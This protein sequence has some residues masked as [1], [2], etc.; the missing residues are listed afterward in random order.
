MNNGKFYPLTLIM[1]TVFSLALVLCCTANF[2]VPQLGSISFS[3]EHFSAVES[4]NAKD[5]LL[6]RLRNTALLEEQVA[7]D[8]YETAD[9]LYDPDRDSQY[10]GATAGHP[11]LYIAL[12]SL[13]LQRKSAGYDRLFHRFLLVTKTP[14]SGQM[15]LLLHWEG[16]P[17]ECLRL[18]DLHLDSLVA[19]DT[20]TVYSFFLA[21]TAAQPRFEIIH[22]SAPSAREILSVSC[23]GRG[24]GS[25][26]IITPGRGMHY[27]VFDRFGRIIHQDSLSRRLHNLEVNRYFILGIAPGCNNSVNSFEIWQP[28][29]IK[30]AIEASD[31][32]VVVG[33]IMRFDNKSAH[34]NQFL[35]DFGDGTSNSVFNPL[36]VYR[37]TG[38]FVVR[39]LA[40]DIHCGDSASQTMRV[41][42]GPEP[43]TG[44]NTA[45][46]DSDFRIAATPNKIKVFYEGQT[47]T[48]ADVRIVDLQGREHFYTQMELSGD[49]NTLAFTLPSGVY[50]VSIQSASSHI[51]RKVVVQ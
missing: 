41:G 36:H 8:F 22:L 46:E 20:Q 18:H 35:W 16:Q 37:D 48:R 24:D 29:P 7:I 26:K 49:N 27:K 34:T 50:A 17:N 51:I 32:S 11:S 39:L 30:A 6:I 9:S 10:P 15:Q 23:F 42:P 5:R 31:T 38:V 25:A 33:Q 28:P 13:H 40:G 45:K 21:D 44:L 12:D 2:A 47:L 19:I 43:A 1:R 3:D 4:P 14:M